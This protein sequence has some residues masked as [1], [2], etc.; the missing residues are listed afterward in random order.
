MVQVARCRLQ[1]GG[2]D[3]CFMVCSC[4]HTFCFVV[5]CLFV[6]AF[7]GGILNQAGGHFWGH[8]PRFFKKLF[9][10][11]PRP[12][13]PRSA[14][15]LTF[16][17]ILAAGV[18]QIEVHPL[19]FLKKVIR[20][21]RTGHDERKLQAPKAKLQGNHKAQTAEPRPGTK[22]ENRGAVARRDCALKLNLWRGLRPVWA[23]RL[24]S[25]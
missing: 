10:A 5:N 19:R 25:K 14:D 20:N 22:R 11:E 16:W 24:H 2:R 9:T 6:S 12:G 4:I 1:V 7:T 15:F 23:N 17:G 3:G 21:I 8:T 13:D 18:Y